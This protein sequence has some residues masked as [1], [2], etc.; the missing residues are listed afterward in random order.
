MVCEIFLQPRSFFSFPLCNLVLEFSP[1]TFVHRSNALACIIF[2]LT[3]VFID[4]IPST[5]C[6]NRSLHHSM[7]NGK[8]R[9]DKMAT[10]KKAK[11]AA[12]K[13]H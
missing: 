8:G 3:S 7:K 4:S 1:V 10:K 13:K 6:N 12:K 5:S 2:F 11:K 9:I